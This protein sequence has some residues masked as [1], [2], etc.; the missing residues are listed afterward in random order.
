MTQTIAMRLAV[1]PAAEPQLSVPG[2]P[3]RVSEV[4]PGT[5]MGGYTIDS[6]IGRGGMGLVFK[7][8]HE[9]LQRVAAVKVLAKYGSSPESIRRFEREA[10]TVAR[11]RHPHIVGVFD[12][13]EFGG[14][15]YM[16]AEYMPNG[17]LQAQMQPGPATP[18][19]AIAVLRPL[20]SA[21]DYAHEQGVIHR[22]VKPANVFLDAEQRPVLA[23]FGLAKLHSDVDLTASG[24]VSGTPSY[25]AP[26]QATGGALT[27]ATDRYSLAVMAYRLCA[28]Q[29]PFNGTAVMD[30]L[31]SH[32]HHIPAPASFHNPGLQPAVDAVLSKGLAKVPTQRW[33]T[34]TEMVDALE[35]AL[36]GT[37]DPSSIELEPL[38]VGAPRTQPRATTVAA[39]QDRRGGIALVAALT[40][41]VSLLAACAAFAI[42]AFRMADRSQPAP[43]AATAAA[44]ASRH[45]EIDHSGPIQLGDTVTLT[46]KG[47]APRTLV[48]V[49]VPVDR[50]HIEE[51][52]SPVEVSTEGSFKIT[53]M[54]P[55]NLKPGSTALRACNL[56][57]SNTATNCIDL[58]VTLSR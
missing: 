38:V 4:G 37:L 3:A 30:V 49:G 48:N 21:L 15:P 29:L 45:I 43:P 20:A 18:A 33:A 47:F 26:E 8:Y 25:I 17:S 19:H 24:T 23:D 42:V 32:V 5:Q 50:S 28:G 44:S 22:D 57:G 35:A 54:V 56:E 34:C 1:V 10:Q 53:F 14:Q 27:G 2:E 46:G 11:L 55:T 52:G 6:L 9:R 13:G 58:P 16:V 41:A 31:Y 51:L 12:F 36:Q 7:A 39:R 40:A